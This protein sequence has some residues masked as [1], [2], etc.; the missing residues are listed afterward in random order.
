MR[1][2]VMFVKYVVLQ[3]FCRIVGHVWL[4]LPADP[5]PPVLWDR[6]CIRC[7]DRETRLAGDYES[8]AWR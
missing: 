7:L 8:G 4:D 5:Y 6:V 1:E 2:A 3:W